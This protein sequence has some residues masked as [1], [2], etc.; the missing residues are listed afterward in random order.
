MSHY[1]PPLDYYSLGIA[2]LLGAFYGLII[3]VVCLIVARRF[4]FL[5]RDNIWHGRIVKLYFLY[6]PLVFMLAGAGWKSMTS[7][8]DSVVE[9]FE[10]ARP[11]VSA[12]SAEQAARLRDELMNHFPAG[13]KI[14]VN[15]LLKLV[16]ADM[17]KVYF[18]DRL[19][20]IHLP[21]SLR[22]TAASLLSSGFAGYMAE[23]LRNRLTAYAAGRLELDES[24]VRAFFD[25]DLTQIL[26]GGFLV[27]LAVT[28]V[29]NAFSPLLAS[30][31]LWFIILLL[32][33]V[34]ETAVALFRQRRNKQA[35]ALPAV[36]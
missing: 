3:A 35:R 11:A 12:A 33:P 6:I 25:T 18:A 31:R 5:K 13:Q 29:K 36:A 32:P 9:L 17:L 2:C 20:P 10:Q 30:I 16:S 24:I 21:D 26:E 4:G 1:L 14:S 8:R 23:E 7:T 28:W 19:Q 22:E 15:A 27:E 34:V